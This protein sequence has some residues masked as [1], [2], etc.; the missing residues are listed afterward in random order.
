MVL[1]DW[2]CDGGGDGVD[3]DTKYVYA[4]LNTTVTD[5]CE[6]RSQPLNNY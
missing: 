6:K 2:G 3:G 5:P 1:L 4:Y